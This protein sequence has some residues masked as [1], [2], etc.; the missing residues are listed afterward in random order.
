M[1]TIFSDNDLLLF[2]YDEMSYD[3]ANELVTALSQDEELLARYEYFQRSASM[4]SF[5]D[6]EPP[7]EAIDAV[8]ETA[9][10]DA[11]KQRRL[12]SGGSFR[13]A[14]LTGMCA[15]AFLITAFAGNWFSTPPVESSK[16]TVTVSKDALWDDAS[17]SDRI[18]NLESRTKALQDPIL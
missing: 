10:A 12:K 7:K 3:R 1:K 2:L 11:E 8:M 17:F 4:I 9:M 16:V 14:L 18:D 15:I 13:T 6:I 5:G